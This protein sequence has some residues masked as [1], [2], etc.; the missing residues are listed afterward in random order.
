[1]RVELG[2]RNPISEY[3]EDDTFVRGVRR[4]M[5][6]GPPRVLVVTVPDDYTYTVAEDGAEM[7][8]GRSSDGS[9]RLVHPSSAAALATEVAAHIGRAVDGISQI[10]DQEALLSVIGAWRRES[11]GMPSWVWSDND[12]FAVLVGAYFE[13]PVGRPVDV[14]ATHHTP[15]GPPGVAGRDADTDAAVAV[16]NDPT[17]A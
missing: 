9:A 6:D 17:E 14:E 1:M 7:Q 2:N 4:E 15:A 12:D 5:L 16:A 11:N 3:D 8:V 10:P 13:C